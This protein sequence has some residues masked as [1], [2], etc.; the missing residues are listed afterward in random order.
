MS[1]DDSESLR[2]LPAPAPAPGHRKPL[3]FF[4]SVRN[5]SNDPLDSFAIAIDV[6]FQLM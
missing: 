5:G 1:V 3:G 4:R 6:V 2:K